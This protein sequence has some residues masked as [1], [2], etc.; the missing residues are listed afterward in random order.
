MQSMRNINIINSEIKHFEF[1]INNIIENI[2]NITTDSFIVIWNQSNF[3][4]D[5]FNNKYLEEIEQLKE[6]NQL[7]EARIF[8][9]YNEIRIFK[10]LG[11]WL[12]VGIFDNKGTE[13]EYFDACQV[14]SGR[15]LMKTDSKKAY[16]FQMGQKTFLGNNLIEKFDLKEGEELKSPLILKTRNYIDYNEIGQCR[17]F[18]TR[19][20]EITK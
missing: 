18:L 8:N 1:S 6:D 10:R 7:L 5:S 4:I 3:I 16:L 13:K 15:K 20:V 12:C 2:Q 9:F 17:I 19:M 14:I 11:N